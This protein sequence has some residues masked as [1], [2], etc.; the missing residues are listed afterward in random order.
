MLVDTER[1]AAALAELDRAGATSCGVWY[2]CGYT[3]GDLVFL[4]GWGLL[5]VRRYRLEHGAGEEPR[6]V[7]GVEIS[8]AGREYVRGMLGHEL[9][10]EA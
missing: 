6:F 5:N 8:A 4:C 2:S 9:K 3:S 7:W 1:R 10:P